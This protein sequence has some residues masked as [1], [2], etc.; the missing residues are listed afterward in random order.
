MHSNSVKDARVRGARFAL[1]ALAAVQLGIGAGFLMRAGW[2]LALW[3][4]PDTP[5]SHRFVASMLLAQGTTVAWVAWTMQLRAARGGI[6]GFAFAAAGL[7]AY[8]ALLYSQRGGDLLLG[9]AVACGILALGAALLFGL[10]GRIP[11]DPV[12]PIPTFVRFSFLVFAGALTVATVLLLVRAPIVF[13]WPL[14]PE[15]SVMFGLLF[16]ASAVYFLDGWLRPGHDNAVG[17][18]LGFL[19]YDA[20]LIAPWLAH[21]PRTQGGFRVSMVIYLIVL[22]WSSLLAI[23]YL[24]HGRAAMRDETPL[25]A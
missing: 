2:A 18:L 4:W 13:P 25:R 8:T 14:K 23:W 19:V 12:R 16:L 7:G 6:L 9:W 5:L 17:Q 20:V 1:V 24:L 3:P 22:G 11:R 15:S 21:L 10:G